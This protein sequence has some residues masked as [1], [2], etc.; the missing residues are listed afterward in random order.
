M[1]LG[2]R[3]GYIMK[4]Y[5]FIGTESN[6]IL[7]MECVDYDTECLILGGSIKKI[8]RFGTSR[9]P[10]IK[11]LVIQEGTNIK[12][13]EKTAFQ[14]TPIEKEI[15]KKNNKMF[16]LDRILYYAKDDY[17]GEDLVISENII[18]IRPFAFEG[19]RTIKSVVIPSNVALIYSGAFSD[20]SIEK[21]TIANGVECLDDAFEG[22]MNLKSV[23]IPPSVKSADQAFKNCKNLESVIIQSEILES[24]IETF[25]NCLNLSNVVVNPKL[26]I[27]NNNGGM[28]FNNCFKLKS[29]NMGNVEIISSGMFS[30]CK[31][32]ENVI[33]KNV[34]EIDPYAF[35]DCK[36]LINI[37]APKLK[38][39]HTGAF[40]NSGIDTSIFNA[41]VFI[42]S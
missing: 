42:S 12:E 18:S 13:I 32:L 36:E 34:K 23:I 30:N 38:K 6:D 2:E 5:K 1:I 9:I 19:F 29:I 40:M 15:L 10:E 3:S 22:C 7:S 35:L 26:T 17:E 37:E 33:M 20:S 28:M 24:A 14:G 39:V 4:T 16:V 41:S 8:K 27:S 31:K 25:R 21:I 11:K